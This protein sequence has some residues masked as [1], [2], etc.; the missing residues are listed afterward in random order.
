MPSVQLTQQAAALLKEVQRKVGLFDLGVDQTLQSAQT[1]QADPTKPLGLD[2]VQKL[3]L[4]AMP[5]QAATIQSACDFAKGYH[6][7]N[8]N[9]RFLTQILSLRIE[10]EHDFGVGT[11]TPPRQRD[12]LYASFTL[13]PKADFMLLFNARDVDAK[14]NPLLMKVVVREGAD[15]SKLDLTRYRTATGQMP[16]VVKVPKHATYV[17]TK[18]IDETEFSF[19]DPLKQVSVA[20]C[21][22]QELSSSVWVRPQNVDRWNAYS[23]M[24]DGRQ[25]VINPNARQPAQDRVNQ[26]EQLDTTPVK[27]FDERVRLGMKAKDTLP[28][29]AWLDTPGG[30]AQVDVSLE[31]GRGF[32]FEPGANCEVAFNGMKLTGAIDKGDAQLLGNEASSTTGTP[33][34]NGS[35]RWL[36]QQQVSFAAGANPNGN[37]R[38]VTSKSAVELIYGA[39]RDKITVG[40]AKLSPLA[41]VT[42]K[43]GDLAANKI[44]LT[45]E[46]IADPNNDSV[47]VQLKLDDAFLGVADGA[48]VKGWKMAVGYTDG[49]GTWVSVG[50]RGVKTGASKAETFSFDVDDFD[51]LQQ[52]DKKLE[53][54]LFNADGVPAQRVI[55]PFREVS[56]AE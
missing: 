29:D 7:D 51:A 18:D 38:T 49:A 2:D 56:W 47:K 24:W 25:Y 33:G 14:G 53:V 16:D 28:A 3:L 12:P 55:L 41:D 43:A 21:G 5:A 54:R 20:S 44:A 50:E 45:A 46:P 11:T 35:L 40:G 48:S 19:G 32:I 9:P 26:G 27:T 39:T 13:D 23:Y 15:V 10:K 37:D 1:G 8:K 6:P 34:G 31:L 36:L 30:A 52:G 22:T 4:Q 42:L 17:E